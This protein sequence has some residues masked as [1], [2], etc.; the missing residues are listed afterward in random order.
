M[1]VSWVLAPGIMGAYQDPIYLGRDFAKVGPLPPFA[2]EIP[3]GAKGKDTHTHDRVY[4]YT[5]AC[6][7]M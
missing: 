6:M 2:K 1:G 5:H 4:E 3:C 7:Y